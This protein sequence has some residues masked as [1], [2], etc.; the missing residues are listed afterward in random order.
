MEEISY[1]KEMSVKLVGFSFWQ[2]IQADHRF[3][4]LRTVTERG[5]KKKRGR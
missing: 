3:L 5:K 4:S 1:R 2:P